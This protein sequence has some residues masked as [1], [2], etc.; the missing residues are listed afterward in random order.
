[1][2]A[3]EDSDVRSERL[4]TWALVVEGLATAIA[5]LSVPAIALALVAALLVLVGICVPCTLCMSPAEA[6]DKKGQQFDPEAQQS[7]SMA[8]AATLEDVIFSARTREL[9]VERHRLD[10]EKLTLLA[11]AQ[12]RCCHALMCVVC[13]MS[14]IAQKR[15]FPRTVLHTSTWQQLL[16]LRTAIEENG[17]AIDAR[18][19]Q[20][21]AELRR[22]KCLDWTYFCVLA[23]P[24]LSACVLLATP[25]L[26]YLGL[27][28]LDWTALDHSDPRPAGTGL[29]SL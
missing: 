23:L 5:L 1:M 25:T 26:G 24:Q 18:Q 7:P 28:G 21:R 8:P 27:A 15:Y 22:W 3:V 14:K 11:K 9:L 17:R 16:A 4:S 19:D 20:R 10:D 6:D 29:A 13:C 12:P 2:S